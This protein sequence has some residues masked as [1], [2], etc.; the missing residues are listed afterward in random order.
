MK[1]LTTNPIAVRRSRTAGFTLIELLVVIAV[2]VV[3]IS[4][5][6]PAVQWARE[7]ARRTQCKNNLAQIGVAL[8]NYLMMHGVLP[9]GTQNNTGPIISKAGG[10]Y[11]MGWITQILPHLEQQAVYEHIDFT[12]SVYDECHKDVRSQNLRVLACPTVP[13]MGVGMT[14]YS[15]V[16]NDVE[17]PIDVDQNGVLFLNSSVDEDQIADGCANTIFVMENGS[18]PVSSL[19]WMSGS[20]AS[21]CNAVI[22][23]PLDTTNSENSSDPGRWAGREQKYELH[24]S[25]MNSFYTNPIQLRK[26]IADVGSNREFVGGPTSYHPGIFQV[27]MGDGSVRAISTHIYAKTLRNLAH[28]AD[29]AMMNDF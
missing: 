14:Q 21:L 1:D 12:K 26:E 16:H 13:G 4:L 25:T 19:G 9:P 7:A 24:P 11:H 15:G 28:R 10:G 5:L 23:I 20:R 29:G 6:L 22:A 2:I 27:T 18:N 17:A 3:L 8:N